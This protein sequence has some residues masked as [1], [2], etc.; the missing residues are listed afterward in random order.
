[1]DA[2][3]TPKHSSW[4]NQIECWWGHRIK[5]DVPRVLYGRRPM[6][7]TEDSPCGTLVSAATGWVQQA[8]AARILAEVATRCTAEGIPFLAVKG[9]V[10]SHTL[11]EDVAMRPISDVDIR[12]KPKDYDRFRRMAAKAGWPCLRVTR[13]YR[14]LV[15]DFPALAL[16]VE[17]QVGPPGLC[18][19]RTE[20]MLVRARSLRLDSQTVVGI[21]ETHD[22][23]VHL[24]INVF[25]DKIAT[26]L[27]FAQEDLARI[28]LQPDFRP[29]VFVQRCAAARC[30]TI[31]HL[32]ASW[33][34][35]RGRVSWA[36]L[37]ALLEQRTEIRS[38]YER[39]FHWLM[40]RADATSLAVRLVARIG[41]DSDR[42]RARAI[43]AAAAL[44]VEARLR[45]PVPE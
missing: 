21:P 23:A 16:D 35:S 36:R 30:V 9:A 18:A 17:C 43:V 14:N 34:D 13:S 42:L 15:Y 27:P 32:V 31:A 22:H 4:L 26:A 24:T 2:P 33:M 25:K 45:R 5:R 8:A 11:Y 39:L 38:G 3:V 12:I 44:E 37:R 6:G 20:D 1:M 19:L 7:S 40:A 10:T 28:I 29:E 41:S